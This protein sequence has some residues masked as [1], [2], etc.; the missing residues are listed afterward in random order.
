MKLF[1]SSILLILSFLSPNLTEIRKNFILASDSKEVSEKLYTAL[2]NITK[3]SKPILVA[4]KGASATLKAKHSK[5]IKQKKSF[6]KE[7]VGYLEFSIEKAPKN[8]EIRCLRL[9][10]Q[11]NSPKILK[12]QKNI[13]EDKQFL[14]DN[15]KKITDKTIKKF[16]KDYVM[17]SSL[18]DASEKKLF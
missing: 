7:G 14:I 1:F 10:V 18:F 13:E 15:Y 3:E 12:Y 17:Q 5:G 9:S 16:I 2:E 11:E 4:Y 6:F 8:I